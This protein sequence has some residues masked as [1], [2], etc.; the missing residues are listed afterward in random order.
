MLIK[1]ATNT[2]ESKKNTP[3]DATT[4]LMIAEELRDK[5]A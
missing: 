3:I 2:P 1:S 5:P 4:L